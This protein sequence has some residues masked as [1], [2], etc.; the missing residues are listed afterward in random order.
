MG[1]QEIDK[2]FFFLNTREF[3][4]ENQ[5]FQGYTYLEQNN[6]IFIDR[7]EGNLIHVSRRIGDDK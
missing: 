5:S 3:P 1:K 2:T 6:N 7:S 4:K